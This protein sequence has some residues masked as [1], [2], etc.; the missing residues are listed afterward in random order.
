MRCPPPIL[1]AFV[2]FA[3]VVWTPTFVG[4]QSA[5]T[6]RRALRKVSLVNAGSDGA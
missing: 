5:P 4:G 1:P 3:L 2:V 6:D